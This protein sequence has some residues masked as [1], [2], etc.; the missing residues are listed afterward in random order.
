MG[1][2]AII[3]KDE[4]RGLIKLRAVFWK[5]WNIRRPSND[6]PLTLRD[7]TSIRRRSPNSRTSDVHQTTSPDSRT[8]DV[9]QT[10][11]P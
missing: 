4:G 6:E 8:S 5:T 2:E 9:H 10:T 7:Q 1:E 3:V 11:S